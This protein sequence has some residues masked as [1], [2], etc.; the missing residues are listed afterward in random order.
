MAERKRV[1]YFRNGTLGKIRD[2]ADTRPALEVA[3][4]DCTAGAAAAGMAGT[5]RAWLS[6]SQVDAIDRI[7]DVGPWYRVD[8]ETLL[9]ATK[10]EL[11]L[12]PRAPI[13]LTFDD[14]G[15]D[16]DVLFWTGTDL[17]GRRTAD[18]C[19]DWTIYMVPAVATVGRADAAGAAWVAAE[20]LLCSNYLALLCV[21][22]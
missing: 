21:E 16:D 14:P 1:F 8:Q 19:M 17:D 22:Q 2:S 4:E 20:P 9:F 13:D 12:G 7:D 15:A 6:S 10:A 5:W 3:D 11:T 18:N